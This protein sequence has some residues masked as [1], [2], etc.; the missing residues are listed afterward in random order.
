MTVRNCPVAAPRRAPLPA[1]EVLS[2]RGGRLLAG[3]V[4]TLAL[5]AAEGRAQEPAAQPTRVE[6]SAAVT[7]VQQFRADVTGGGS[8]SVFRTFASADLAVPVGRDLRVG[9][10]LSYDY[11]NYDFHGIAGFPVADPWGTVQR[12]ALSV[13]IAWQLDE[14]WQLRLVPSVQYAGEN[15]ADWGDALIYGGIVAVAARISPQLTLGAGVGGFAGIEQVRVFPYLLVNWQISER[16][17][18]A[19]PFRPGPAGPAGLELLYTLGDD[20]LLAGG[21]AYRSYRQ[22]LA[23]HGPVPDG[24]GELSGYPVFLS[25]SRSFGSWLRSDLWAGVLCGGK[26]S[27]ETADGGQLAELRSDPAPFLGLT[28][29]GRW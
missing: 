26:L 8:Y 1:Q 2:G 25:L 24:I 7:P 23:A 29:S 14:R 10:G 21:A 18:L 4:I 9:L 13:P 11:E 22:R 12:L 3:I 5:L 20:W 19:N 16:L 28:L 27:L 17:R 6:T 15:D